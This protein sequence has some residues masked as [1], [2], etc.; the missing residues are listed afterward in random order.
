M[1]ERQESEYFR[2]KLKA[3]K[4]ICRGWV[5]PQDLPSNSEVRDQIQCLARLHEGNSR[6]ENLREMRVEA[7]RIMRVLRAFRPHLIGS[8]LTGHVRHGSD[9]DLHVFC[10]S[11]ESV[12]GAM[13]AEGVVFDVERKRVRKHGE[14][15]VY[16][17]I[18]VNDRFPLELTIYAASLVNYAFTS[19]ITGKPIERASIAELEQLLVR[20]YPELALEEAVLEAESKIDR[21]QIYQML[22]LPLERVKQSPKYHPEGD[23]LYH[24]LQVFDLACDAQPYDE[25]FLLA[26]LLH[27]VGKG[28]DPD[29]HV[30]AALEALQG[31][32]T[33]RTAWL[34]EHHMEAAWPV[35]RYDRPARPAPARSEREL[36]RP[37]AVGRVRP[38]RSAAR[39]RDVRLGRSARVFA[40]VGADLRRLNRAADLNATAAGPLGDF[41]IL[42]RG[43]SNSPRAGVYSLS[44]PQSVCS[45][46]YR[47]LDS[48]GSSFPL[49]SAPRLPVPRSEPSIAPVPSASSGAIS[50]SDGGREIRSLRDLS[51]QQWK[52][53]AAAWLGWLFDGLDMHLYTLVAV[54]VVAL[55]LGEHDTHA[56]RVA[57][58]SSWIQA[59]FLVGWAVGGGF[60]GR[61]G[62]RLGRSFT[63]SLTILTYAT[64]TGLVV[65]RSHLVGVIDFP[66]RG[67]ARHRRRMGRRRIALV[68][69][70]AERLAPLDRRR[71]A[72]GR[73]HWRAR[74][75]R[76]GRLLSTYA[77]PRVLF[78]V[79]IVPALLVLW[80]R[81]QVP[82]TAEWHTAKLAAGRTP[83]IFELF[84]SGIRRTTCLTILVCSL[85]L[86]AHWAFM[87]WYQ[88]QMQNLPDVRDWLPSERR[89]LLSGALVLVM[90]ASI[91]G[92]FFAAWLARRFGYRWAISLLCLGYGLTM[93]YTYSTPRDFRSLLVWLP[94]VGIFQG[95][96]AL[97]T[98]YL[99]PL[100]PTLLRTTG[101]GFCY[102]IGRLVA[103]AGTIFFG[104]FRELGDFRVGL[105]Y[106]SLLF[107]PTALVALLLP[108]PPELYAATPS[109]ADAV[110]AEQPAA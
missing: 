11:I 35:R 3:A 85:S 6:T 104:R 65:L 21:F 110:A 36:R 67:G 41:R 49:A 101:A 8:T 15:R 5:K 66:V 33:P 102:N 13:E 84:G 7:L 34:I 40:R 94:I 20:E 72:V 106:A 51:P 76:R 31:Y 2:A 96:F 1:Y 99:P 82:E 29:D 87:F 42:S 50:P 26:A 27:D 79:G 75:G 59:S 46:V 44:I 16:T 4:R 37:G 55:L 68:G 64:F 92:N 71:A 39:R 22:L 32:I 28:I 47:F 97:F 88:Q 10:D 69:N 54:P 95:V 105:L 77:D 100:F 98:M 60:F 91:V 90:V 24:S 70:L 58:I 14:E 80:I 108:E 62:D 18:H 89:Q 57:E 17:H 48:V 38:W 19:S 74:S 63:L 12:A 25:E 86:T 56:D 73:E 103:A 30:A 78:L 61:L 81:W 52:S 109:E 43:Y 9:I 93:A 53:G 107:L 45:S 83:S 23:A